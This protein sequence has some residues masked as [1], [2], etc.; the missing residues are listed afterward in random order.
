MAVGVHPVDQAVEVGLHRGGFGGGTF[1]QQ[2]RGQQLDG[3]A[4][5]QIIEPQALRHGAKALEP[6]GPGPA[7]APASPALRT[8]RGPPPAAGRGPSGSSPLP[9]SRC[10]CA[11][12]RVGSAAGWPSPGPPAPR[13]APFPE[14]HQA[15]RSELQAGHVA[16]ER[17][18]GAGGTHRIAEAE[19][20][21]RQAEQGQSRFAGAIGAPAL[22]EGEH[23]QAESVRRAYRSRGDPHALT[24]ASRSLER[25][26]EARADGAA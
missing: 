5:R 4:L 26:Q 16:V 3:P 2:S 8:W 19:R 22:R 7:S 11:R 24:S 13:A 15:Q 25:D 21:A 18:R 12:D 14:G 6:R 10:W 9:G 20:M 1:R 17:R 23:A